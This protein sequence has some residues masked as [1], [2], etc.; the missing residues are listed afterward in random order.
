M[1]VVTDGTAV[2]GPGRHRPRGGDAG[3][4]G[5]G[6]A[7]QGVRRRRRL[8]DLPRPPRTP[9]RSSRPCKAI[10]PGF[11]GINLEDIAAPRCFEIEERLRQRAR[12]PGL[13]RRPARHR[14]RGAGGAAQR[15]QD[16]AASASDELKVVVVRR[17]RGRR[18]HQQDPAARRASATSSAATARARCS[19]A[20]RG[21]IGDQEAGSPSTPTR[22]AST[23][24]PTTRCAGADVFIGL[25]GP[26][27][28]TRAT[29]MRTMAARRDRVRDGQP[30]A[31]DPA[32]GGRAARPGDG[33]R[34]LRLSRT[35]STTCSASR[36][37][38]AARSTRAPPRSTRR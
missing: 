35:R 25:S 36:A 32:R 18:R 34:P 10:A 24:P 16:R 3:D 14:G 7:L 17:R 6:D 5:Q 27:A 21:L 23:A 29:T 33:H 19:P 13:P 12:H 20:R 28:L 15:A 26:G 9:T 30:R 11:G 38:S 2:L 31:R 1:A 4:G 8:P 37:S 22:A